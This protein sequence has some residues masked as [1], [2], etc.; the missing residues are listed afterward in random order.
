MANGNGNGSTHKEIFGVIKREGQDKAYWARIG[1]GFEN[2]DGSYTLKFDFV[3]TD[4]ETGIQLR[5]PKRREEE[6]TN[7]RSRR[8]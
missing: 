3:P 7:G 1:T 5:D 2:R 6:A 4:S 8:D